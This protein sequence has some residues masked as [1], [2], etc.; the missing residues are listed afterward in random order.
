MMPLRLTLFYVASFFVGGPISTTI[1]FQ[2]APFALQRRATLSK[3]NGI[4]SSLNLLTPDHA[5]AV[6]ALLNIDLSNLDHWKDAASLLLADAGTA[7][8]KEEDPGLWQQFLLIFKNSLLF[9][10]ATIDGP[11]R[12]LGFEQTWGVSIFL[13]TASKYGIP[14]FESDS[15]D[16]DLMFVF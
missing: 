7:V 3:T 13:F 15:A 14:N 16:S 9:V 6:Q 11:L 1:A 5:D 2:V 4:G 8:A 10:H 12:S